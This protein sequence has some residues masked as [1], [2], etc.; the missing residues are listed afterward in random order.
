MPD[1]NR[2]SWV[3]AA[4]A[5]WPTF[6][7]SILTQWP[8]D[9][10]S[11]WPRT[12]K[13]IVCGGLAAGANEWKKNARNNR[14]HR[15]SPGARYGRRSDHRAEVDAQDDGNDRR[16]SST[17][18]YSGFG[19]YRLA[20]SIPN[21]F[22]FARQSEADRHQLQSLPGSAISAD[23][24]AAGS[25]PA[26]R[27]SHHQRR[28]QETRI[29]WQLQKLRR[30]M[31]SLSRSGERSRLPLRCQRRGHLLRHLR[32][33]EQPRHCLRRHLARYVGLR[34]PFHRYLVETR[35]IAPP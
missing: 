35:G 17:D 22:L 1:W 25:L 7:N 33:A 26:S 34:R 8:V 9:D 31:G 4:I 24:L 13:W 14:C 5:A 19:E 10:S 27:P 16:T 18:R 30:Q 15:D 6:S 12:W 20:P 32:P 21:G 3:A 11:C 29:D 23:L 28:Q 2:S